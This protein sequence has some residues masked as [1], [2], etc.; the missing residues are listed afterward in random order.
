M[1]H[2]LTIYKEQEKSTLQEIEDAIRNIKVIYTLT[3]ADT[4]DLYSIV[5]SF[6][7]ITQT[8]ATYYDKECIKTDC[9]K[10]RW[11]SFI[12]CYRYVLAI[13]PET[14]IEKVIEA[15]SKMIKS[16]LLFIFICNDVH[17]NVLIPVVPFGL[18][19]YNI[20]SGCRG[21]IDASQDDIVYRRYSKNEFG[22]VIKEFYNL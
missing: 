3:P 12:D 5:K 9:I 6:F 21:G 17:R 7:L 14:K 10:G 11:R 16:G 20:P 1:N 22:W 8:E 15:V 18:T 19:G 4:T 13:L 2:Y